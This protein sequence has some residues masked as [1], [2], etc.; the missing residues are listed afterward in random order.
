MILPLVGLTIS[1]I[2]LFGT[3][4]LLGITFNTMAVALVPLL[5]G[6]GVD[7]SV[8]M[9]HNYR[10]ELEKGKSCGE[11]I[12]SSIQDVGMAM[13]LATITTMVAAFLSFLTA[14]IPPIRDFGI[15]CAIGIGLQLVLGI[16]S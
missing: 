4:V 6:L 2:W 8:H 13:F 14:S 16:R 3:M 10:V 11:A 12:V 5:M 7:Y 1:I 9:F 15:L